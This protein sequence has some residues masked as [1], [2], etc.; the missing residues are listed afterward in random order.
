MQVGTEIH[1]LSREKVCPI[2]LHHWNDP[3]VLDNCNHIF[4]FDCIVE[5]TKLKPVCPLCKCSLELLKHRLWINNNSVLNWETEGQILLFSENI[6]ELRSEYELERLMEKSSR[7]PEHERQS[8]IH[9]VKHMLG[10]LHALRSLSITTYASDTI[11]KKA[12]DELNKELEEYKELLINFNTNQY[13]RAE[14]FKSPAFRRVVYK[15]NLSPSSIC[16][17]L[18]NI[19]LNADYI[20]K[21]RD[22]VKTHIMPFVIREI[23]A[24]TRKSPLCQLQSKKPDVIE[25]NVYMKNL[26]D[27]FTKKIKRQ[28][29]VTFLSQRGIENPH[30]FLNNLLHFASSGQTLRVYDQNSE[31]RVRRSN[32]VGDFFPEDDDVLILN[33]NVDVE[34]LGESNSRHST[35]EHSI[36]M[37]TSSSPSITYSPL[38]P[39]HVAASPSTPRTTN[40]FV[41]YPPEDNDDVEIIQVCNTRHGR[42]SRSFNSC[43]NPDNME[44]SDNILNAS[45]S[46][47]TLD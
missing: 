2:C 27:Y 28:Q 22:I 30:Q 13:T 6:M 39:N 9:L 16:Q 4:C 40:Y 32:Y 17:P 19:A 29:I 15:E 34:V 36:P 21:N 26:M 47:Y 45:P 10:E 37:T 24:L 38:N 14:L 5:W 44:I 1:D 43:M 3:T 42:H 8:V 46:I 12:I 20:K 23:S 7:P 11:F 25:I 31:Y 18:F 41:E 33:T 35:A